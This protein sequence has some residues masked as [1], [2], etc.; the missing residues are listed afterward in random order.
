MLF[1]LTS[2]DAVRTLAGRPTSADIAAKRVLL[3]QQRAQEQARLDSLALADSLAR[4]LA[5][6]LQAASNAFV[7]PAMVLKLSS[8]TEGE[9]P[10]LPARYYVMVG[11]FSTK[12]KFAE[13]VQQAQKASYTVQPI[14]LYS[15]R[16]TAVAVCPSQTLQEVS[17]N[18]KKVIKEK[19][20]PKDAFILAVE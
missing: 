13:K 2:C 11:S 1:C 3:E 16:M 5:D 15:N 7:A 20:C 9:L 19:F 8:M 17:E 6:S 14:P 18:Y 10:A 4:A 12:E